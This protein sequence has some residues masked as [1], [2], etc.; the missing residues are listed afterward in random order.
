MKVNFDH[1]FIDDNGRAVM[2]SGK[3]AVFKEI[4]VQALLHS[5]SR[6]DE[7]GKPIEPGAREKRHRYD[8]AVKIRNFGSN[9][10]IGPEDAALINATVGQGYHPL[11]AGAVSYLLE[12]KEPPKFSIPQAEPAPVEQPKE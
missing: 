2:S 12:G 7:A 1:Q 9:A 5:A 11:V 4:A 10:E 6:V 8:L 3:P